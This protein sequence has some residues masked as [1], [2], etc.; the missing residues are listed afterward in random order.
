MPMRPGQAVPPVKPREAGSASADVPQSPRGLRVQMQEVLK[1]K[2]VRVQSARSDRRKRAGSSSTAR[3]TTA[4]LRKT[5]GFNLDGKWVE[6]P[7]LQGAP[8]HGHHDVQGS[9]AGSG[10]DTG[11]G[12][13]GGSHHNDTTSSR[14][15]DLGGGPD[16]LGNH[17]TQQQQQQLIPKSV[18]LTADDL[19]HAAPLS[20]LTHLKAF[21]MHTIQSIET[22]EKKCDGLEAHLRHQQ[23][24]LKQRKKTIASLTKETSTA[25]ANAEQGHNQNDSLRATLL[26]LKADVKRLKEGNAVLKRQAE[27]AKVN[28]EVKVGV[29]ERLHDRMILLKDEVRKLHQEDTNREEQERNI[30]EFRDTMILERETQ[31]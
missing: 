13:G 4:G 12:G 31:R 24:Q 30:V 18:P 19:D 1:E 20:K 15:L 9:G 25:A 14:R 27:G 11:G 22:I 26:N 7:V 6:L 17:G 3:P 21:V 8:H 5:V 16:S 23:E 2:R 28:R 29:N 10:G